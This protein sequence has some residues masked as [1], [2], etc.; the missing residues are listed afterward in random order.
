MAAAAT[1]SPKKKHIYWFDLTSW[2]TTLV[3]GLMYATYW[4]TT[5]VGREISWVPCWEEG[6]QSH[7]SER[8]NTGTGGNTGTLFLWFFGWF[9]INIETVLPCVIFRTLIF[10]SQT[11][12]I[13]SWW[14]SWG[15]REERKTISLVVDEKWR[16]GEAMV[17]DDNIPNY[18]AQGSQFECQCREEVLKNGEEGYDTAQNKW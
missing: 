11:G 7:S 1:L 8:E 16:I 15:S 17:L 13:E 6:G 2:T 9:C 18:Y 4:N 5:R 3:K 14:H 10:T 12:Q